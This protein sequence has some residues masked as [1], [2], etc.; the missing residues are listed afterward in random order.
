MVEPEHPFRRSQFNGTTPFA[1]RAARLKFDGIAMRRMK[2]E[3]VEM[4]CTSRRKNDKPV[5]ELL[6]R[7]VLPT[8]QP[9]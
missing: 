4:V 9:S 2:T 8:F 6:K 7:E 5:P 1:E 3:P